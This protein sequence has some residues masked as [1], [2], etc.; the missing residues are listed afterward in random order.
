MPHVPQFKTSRWVST[1]N[2]PHTVVLEGQ[3]TPQVPARHASPGGHAMPHAPQLALSW[4]GST[5]LAPH[6]TSGIAHALL[7]TPSTQRPARQSVFRAQPPP[8]AHGPHTLP[9]QSTPVS[10]PF[11]RPSVQL[12]ATHRPASQLPL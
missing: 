6:E 8:S 1:Q 7:Q 2:G 10:S 4:R 11:F 3:V 5:Q 12:G 9:P